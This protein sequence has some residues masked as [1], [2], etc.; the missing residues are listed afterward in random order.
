[1]WL[2]AFFLFAVI[3]LSLLL[4]WIEARVSEGSQVWDFQAVPIRAASDPVETLSAATYSLCV[5]T[6]AGGSKG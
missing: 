2:D 5:Q 1:M 6:S 3:I 4:L